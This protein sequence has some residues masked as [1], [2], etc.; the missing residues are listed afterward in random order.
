MTHSSTILRIDASMRKT[1]SASRAL[2]DAI[3]ASLKRN[4]E[5]AHVITRDLAANPA[6]FVDEDWITANF[7]PED[8]RNTA[9]KAAL[10]ASDTLVDELMAADTLVIGVPIYNFSI[11]AALKAWVDMIVRARVTFK[12]MPD[13]RPVGLLEGKKAI[14]AIASGGVEVDSHY[15]LATPYMRQILGFMGITNVTI[16]AADKLMADPDRL[17]D[18]L[19]AL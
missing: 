4:E 10:T 1:G 2:S 18:A 16:V 14:L 9:N 12:Y 17:K 11:P 13:G 15:D 5:H 7:T 3:V 8:D 6:D 19:A